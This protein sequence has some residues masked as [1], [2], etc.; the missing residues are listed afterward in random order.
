MNSV[1]T[2][3]CH[4]SCPN[5]SEGYPVTVLEQRVG[6][7]QTL[8][9][10]GMLPVVLS[11]LIGEI[12]NSLSLQPYLYSMVVAAPGNYFRRT[13]SRLRVGRSECLPGIQG[14]STL[15]LGGCCR[16]IEQGFWQGVT[17]H[18]YCSP[19]IDT[20][21]KHRTLSGPWL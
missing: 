4:R 18:E 16:S 2:C 21:N 20:L 5:E 7:A 12:I 3:W 6:Y 9:P 10:F 15:V 13:N 19:L 8:K 17:L 1:C 14:S 11:E